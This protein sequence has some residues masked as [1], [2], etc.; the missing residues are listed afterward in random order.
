M[1]ANSSNLYEIYSQR[2]ND[3]LA[4]AQKQ[5]DIVVKLK[6][7]DIQTKGT[8]QGEI[9]KGL[10]DRLKSDKLR[11]LVVGRFSA[12]KSTFINALFGEKLLP[13]T[14]TPTTGVLCKITYAKEEDKKVTL[15]PKKGMGLNGDQPFDIPVNELEKYIRIDHVNDSEVTSK[16]KRM[17]LQWP[18]K[19]C[20]NGVELIDSVGLDDPDSR[21]DITLDYAKSVDAVLYLMKSQDTGSKKDLDTINLLRGLGYESLF[22]IITYYDHI[23]ESAAVGEQSEKEFQNFVFKNLS[24]LTELGDAGIKFIDSRSAL[25]GKIK[26][27]TEKVEESGIDTLEKSLESFLVEQKGRAK[28]LTTLRSLDSVNRAVRKVI[29]SRIDMIQTSIEELE[30]RYDEAK[31]PLK[32]LETKRQLMVNK[33]DSAIA[34]IAREVYDIADSYFLELPG[35]IPAW[36]DEYNIESGIGFPPRKSTLEPVVKEVLNHLKL[37]IE[38]DVS[39]WTT[40]TLSP[41]I[42]ER[43]QQMQDDLENEGQEFLKSA[44]QLRLSISIGDQIS[45]EE[46]AKQKEPSIWGRL[47]SGG[48]ILVTGDFITGGMGMVMGL[49]AMLKTMLIQ[50][51]AGIILI[52]FNLLNPIAIIAAVIASILAGSFVNIF[53]LKSGIKKNV[54]K[55]LCE[56]LASRNRD[57]AMRVKIQVEEKLKE[58]RNALDEGLAGEISSISA[59]VEQILDERK[60]G[61]L[62][63]QNE[64]QKLRQLEEENL[65]LDSKLNHLMFEAGLIH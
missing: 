1:K 16:Y 40:Q 36:G 43:V 18:L 6:M 8:K 32:L 42:A 7:D 52:I 3:L 9:V 31:L 19:L 48:Y 25:L 47:L 14:P 15:Y 13:A 5:S 26:K 46:L 37:K 56:E 10:I 41:I 24:P 62:D 38:S 63:I 20:A 53:S 57:L 55:K 4:L 12:G 61:R 50:L 64:V 35:K 21:D 23:K 39:E 28:L 65:E 22:F 45:D 49:K 2:R 30:K 58:L 59:E 27:D 29:P 60:Q 11:V 51:V 44:N 34:D 54:S 17:D 33:V